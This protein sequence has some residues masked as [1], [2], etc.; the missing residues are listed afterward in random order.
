MKTT[1][2]NVDTP[3]AR[4]R[5]SKNERRRQLLDTALSIV[6][7][8][9]ADRL[10]LASLA[11]RA[12][13][14]KPVTYDHFETRSG[15]L[16]ELYRWIDD[17]QVAKLKK[18]VTTPAQSVNDVAQVLAEAYIHCAADTGGEFYAVGAA[19][20]GSE[21]KAVVYQQLLDNGVQMFVSVL[22]PHTDLPL[23]Q[24]EA[25]CV[26]LVG[27]GEALSAALLRGTYTESQAT[28]AFASI[29]RGAL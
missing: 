13:V 2:D 17:V 12:G 8:E 27:A 22:A 25:R 1:M 10:T 28:Q 16:I 21:E 24:L 29:L 5:L 7:E 3:K 14:S 20:A 18:A 9:G 15:L 4:Q 23:P 19:L 26:G 6:R 11:T